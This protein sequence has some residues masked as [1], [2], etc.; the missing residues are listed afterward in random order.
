MKI[1]YSTIFAAILSLVGLAG[2]PFGVRAVQLD[3]ARQMETVAFIKGFL[4]F[5]KD[6]GYNTVV[7]Y[8]EGRVKTKS[9]PFRPDADAYTPDQM[10]E[11][12]AEAAALGIDIVPVVSVLAHAENFVGC[13]ELQHLSE[14]RKMPGRFGGCDKMTF[15]HS[16]PETRAFLEGYLKELF[17]IFPGRN[18]HV[19]LDESFNTGFCPLCATKMETEG[20]GGIYMDVVD[21]A[22]GFLAR[23]GKRMWMWDDFF[24]FFPERV[25]EVP[26]D[27]VMCNWEYSPDVSVERGPYGHFGERY[28]RNWVREYACRGVDALVCPWS[29]AVNIERMSAYGDR[30]GA[31]GALLT[32]WEMSEMFHSAAL[33][34]V[35]AVGRWWSSGIGK[36]SFD[37]TLDSVLAE[38]FPMLTDEERGAVKV[39]LYDSRRLRSSSSVSAYLGF[40]ERPERRSA[41]ALA[42]KMLRVSSLKPLSGDVPSDPFSPAAILDDIVAQAEQKGHRDFFASIAPR[43]A[44]VRRTPEDVASAKEEVRKREG[45][46]AALCGRRRAQESAWRPGCRPNGTCVPFDALASMCK[47]VLAIDETAAKDDEWQLELEFVLPDFHGR[48]VWSVYAQVDGEWVELVKRRIWKPNE[49]ENAYFERIVPLPVRLKTAPTA[50]KI[51]HDGYGEAGLAHI[52]LANR[53]M[54]L[55]PSGLVSAT[56]LVRSPENVLEDTISATWFGDASTREQMLNPFRGKLESSVTI[57]MGRGQLNQ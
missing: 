37:A 50:L 44:S 7:L 19:G 11:V 6:S 51:V 49:G 20:L 35:R 53:S 34:V 8:L 14:E 13:R 9:F 3:L 56:G 10:R 52:A 39:L 12:V 5:A 2:E 15:C 54:R 33:P 18:F 24:E 41:E 17:G 4:R 40:K 31:S 23:N 16:L 1:L 29:N 45:S 36:M 25:K 57:S 26:K 55:M 48:P 28:R 47:N 21:W 27:V 42:V 46:I 38:I 32:Q 43:L 22:H 30:A